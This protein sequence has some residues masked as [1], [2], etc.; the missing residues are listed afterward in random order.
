M[1]SDVLQTRKTRCERSRIILLNITPQTHIR[2][3]QGD[4]IVFR[5]PEDQLRRP[6]LLRK[7]RLERYN[8]YKDALI[9]EAADKGYVMGEKIEVLF[10]IPVPPSWRK[11]KKARYHFTPHRSKPDVDNLCKALMDALKPTK[12]HVVH[13]LI[14]K[15]VWVDFPIGWIRIGSWPDDLP[16]NCPEK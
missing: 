2:S 3:T 13:T 11:A 7:K 6:G 16:Q 8:S 12:D 15:K 9:D 14:A 5:I 10:Y 4:S 1:S